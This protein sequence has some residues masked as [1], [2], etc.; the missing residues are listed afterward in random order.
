MK[1]IGENELWGHIKK[2]SILK[3][4][5]HF[6]VS[7][8]HVALSSITGSKSNSLEHALIFLFKLY[9]YYGSLRVHTSSI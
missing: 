4:H 8:A 6:V 2:A 9:F 7:D 5:L 3:V 1:Q